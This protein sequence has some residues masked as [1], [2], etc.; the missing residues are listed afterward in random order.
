M[1]ASL[2]ADPDT[3]VDGVPHEQLAELRRTTPVA[4]Q[5]MDGEPGFHAVLTHADVLSVARR[6]TLFSASEGGVVVEDLSPESLAMMRNMLLAMDPPRHG[7]YRRPLVDR[8][9]GRVIAELEP[10]VRTI[11]RHIMDEAAEGG[12]VEFVHDVTSGLP[13]RVIG[14]LMGLPE[15]DWGYIHALAERQTAGQDPD[16]TGNGAPADPS[17]G[18]SPE[19]DHG[20][21][22]EMALYAIDFAAARR[23]AEPRADLTTL[24]LEGDFGGQ[25]MS[26]VDFGSFFVQLVTAGND[27]TKTMLSSGL[28]ALLTHPDQ[29]A[30]V[31]ADPGLVP[32]AVEEVLRWANP[33]HYFRRTATADTELHGVPIRAGDKVAMYYTSAN[34]DED[35]F[36]DP[37]RFD[38]RR[39]PNP[40]LS[41]GFGEHFCLGVHLARLE[42]QVFFA[43]LLAAFPSI[44][45]TGEPVRLRSNLNNG[46]RRLP[47][48]LR[49]DRLDGG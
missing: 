19:P 29:L 30:A 18:A 48:R 12:D 47:V 39:S 36:D 15:A 14:R 21:S 43:E 11:C 44:E 26:D 3:F 38:V 49:R 22:I 6:P 35:V 20:A 33:L 41:F 27:T 32:G 34:R 7:T 5:E 24:I 10:Q 4:W 28:H 8:F 31:R 45:L 13:S 25:P 2:L 23:A 37:Q 17:A 46:L 16:V 1:N 40:H 42:G 9:K